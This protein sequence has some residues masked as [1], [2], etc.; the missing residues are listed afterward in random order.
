M[1]ENI[2][3]GMV[4]FC[5]ILVANQAFGG[6]RENFSLCWHR[7]LTELTFTRKSMVSSWPIIKVHLLVREGCA[8]LMDTKVNGIG[9]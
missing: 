7:E 1:G 4:N 9:N 2:E 3:Q 8:Q 6:A 5:Q